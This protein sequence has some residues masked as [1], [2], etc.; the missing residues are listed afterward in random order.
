MIMIVD[1]ETLEEPELS[2]GTRDE[3]SGIV[4]DPKRGELQIVCC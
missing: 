3:T 2:L 1:I 4:R